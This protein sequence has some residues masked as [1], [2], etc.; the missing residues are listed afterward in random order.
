MVTPVQRCRL[1]AFSPLGDKIVLATN[2]CYSV[3]DSYTFRTLCEVALPNL[4]MQPSS[5]GEV[6]CPDPK[7]V[8]DIRFTGNDQLLIL[9]GHNT[10]T[11]ALGVDRPSHFGFLEGAQ[12]VRAPV[13]YDSFNGLAVV[14]RAEAVLVLAKATVNSNNRCEIIAKIQLAASAVLPVGELGVCFIG[15]TDGT[16]HMVKWPH[17]SQEDLYLQEGHRTYLFDEPIAALHAPPSMNYLYAVSRSGS[18]AICQLTVSSSDNVPT[19]IKQ[20]LV[21]LSDVPLQHNSHW[22]ISK[23]EEEQ[24]ERELIKLR[25][26]EADQ[27]NQ[28]TYLGREENLAQKQNVVFKKEE[29]EKCYLSEIQAYEE[30][31]GIQKVL[32]SILM[33]KDEVLFRR[34]SHDREKAELDQS[35]GKE[36]HSLFAER[37]LLETHLS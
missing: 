2:N 11:L 35:M 26:E 6:S 27:A 8:S 37:R 36:L 13:A 33:L 17:Y 5:L 19:Q 21:K 28:H 12:K 9:S 24:K 20:R 23:N 25:G 15:C 3:L 4:L 18:L 34:K 14:A 29:L 1:A 16:L 31:L 7:A 30:E 32:Q 22:L 10:L